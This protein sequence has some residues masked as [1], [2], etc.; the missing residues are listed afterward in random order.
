MDWQLL[1]TGQC[2]KCGLKLTQTGLLDF[3]FRC[4]SHPTCPFIIKV[5]KFNEIMENMFKRKRMF[6]KGF[7]VDENLEALNNFGHEELTEGFL[8]DN[9]I[10]HE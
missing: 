3:Y 4:S 10:I 1:K 9:K 6:T 8:P 5:T 7:A 2:P